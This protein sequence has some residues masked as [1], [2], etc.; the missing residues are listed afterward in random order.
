MMMA[1]GKSSP[2]F[3]VIPRVKR[4]ARSRDGFSSY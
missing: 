2:I 3:I 1:I 4:S